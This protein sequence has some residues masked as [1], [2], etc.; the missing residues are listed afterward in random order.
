MKLLV[1]FLALLLGNPAMHAERPSGGVPTRPEPEFVF[2]FDRPP[3]VVR[4]QQRYPADGALGA[5]G[6]V[7]TV[8]RGAIQRVPDE[9][10]GVALRFPAPCRGP[11]GNCPRAIVDVPHSPGLNPGDRSFSFGAMVLLQPDETADG[12]NVMQKGRFRTPGV[13]WKL[14]IDGIAGRPSCVFRGGPGRRG[15]SV[16]VT[17]PVSV[18]TGSW[19]RV[20]CV[21]TADRAAVAVDG[22]TTSAPAASVRAL[23]NTAPVRLGGPALGVGADQYH[24]RLDDVF[25]RIPAG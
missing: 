17:S 15:P 20:R 6:G 24:G 18:A 23:S 2:R 25:L 21:M 5:V 12:S 7:L 4:E 9:S 1:A 10:G 3:D 11:G 16:T 22:L 8:N 19:H 14:Q 13:Q